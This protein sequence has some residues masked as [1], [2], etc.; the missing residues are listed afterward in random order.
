MPFLAAAAVVFF[1]V[2]LTPSHGA[3]APAGSRLTAP[4]QGATPSNGP[5]EN[6]GRKETRQEKASAPEKTA[7][8]SE[9]T[10]SEDRPGQLLNIR[11]EASFSYQVGTG[12][13]LK[14]AIS[15]M[16]ADQRTGSVRS[17]T[18]IPVPAVVVATPRTTDEPPKGPT[19]IN[20]KDIRLNMDVRRAIVDGSSIR[21]Y[22]LLDFNSVDEKTGLNIPAF[23]SFQQAVELVLPNGKPVLVAQSSDYIGDVER[24]Q[25]VEVK[26]TIVK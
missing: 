14:R 5:Q 12:A 3:A 19:P 11:F 15:V 7:A 9:K 13:P 6:T 1:L 10:G 26:A 24:K 23:P 20:Y 18:S 17:T 4:A 8:P 22:V 21:A 25:S 2:T 16:V